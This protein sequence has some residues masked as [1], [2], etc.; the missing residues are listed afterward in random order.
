MSKQ[1]QVFKQGLASREKAFASTLPK[2]IPTARFLRT[3]TS[4]VERDPDLLLCEPNSLYKACQQA[5]QDGLVLDGREAALVT[6]NKNVAARNA[7]PKWEKHAQYMPMV[8]GLLKKARNTGEISSIGAY[9]VKE[10]DG[11][12]YYINE[13]GHC[14]YHKPEF[15]GNRGPSYLAYAMATLKDGSVQIEVMSREEIE[16][17][18]SSSKS[19]NDNDGNPKGI[20][21]K[22]PDEM[23]KKTVLKRLLKYLPSST[24]LDR[25]YEADDKDF[26]GDAEDITEIDE[27]RDVTTKDV[28]NDVI[29]AIVASESEDADVI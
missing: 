17:I 26:M 23:W 27:P 20:W 25:V 13:K 15:R 6:F 22:W 14:L 10:N 21:A 2:Q 4:A 9:V 28:Q 3:A 18:R 7:K 29:D 16:L 5:A 24:E 8:S 12:D 11:F 1:L 19:G